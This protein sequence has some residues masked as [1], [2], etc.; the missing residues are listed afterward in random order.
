M[1]G[2]LRQ[3]PVC[4]WIRNPKGVFQGRGNSEINAYEI[5]SMYIIRIF[6]T[7]NLQ[8]LPVGR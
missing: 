2:N 4:L 1:A 6:D 7:K 5:H 3:D 8:V